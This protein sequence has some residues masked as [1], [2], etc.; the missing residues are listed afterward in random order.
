MRVVSVFVFV[1]FAAGLLCMLVSH[2]D[3]GRSI[4][5]VPLVLELLQERLLLYLKARPIVDGSTRA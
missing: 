5:S 4:V 2:L 3:Q 1:V